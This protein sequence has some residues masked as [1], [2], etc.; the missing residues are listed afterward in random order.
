MISR[1]TL[2]QEQR[3]LLPWSA[4]ATGGAYSAATPFPEARRFIGRAVA[5]GRGTDRC[6]MADKEHE[7]E[8]TVKEA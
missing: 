3:S 4:R 8:M 2:R 6:A 5:H 1:Q 7:G